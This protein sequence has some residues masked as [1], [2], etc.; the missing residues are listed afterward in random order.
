[1]LSTIAQ[2]SG[3]VTNII[4][5]YVFIFPLGMGVAGAAWATVIGQFISLFVAM[6]FHYTCNKEI[7]GSFKYIKPDLELIKGIYNIGIS[8]AIM[9][10]LLSV[11]MAG[12]NAILGTSKA[13]PAI[14][15]GSFGIYYKIQQMALFSAF[16]LSNTIISILS[17]NYGMK[18]KKRINDCIKYG[19]A[20]TIIVTFI[21]TLT[22]EIFAKPLSGLF[23]LTGGTTKEIINVCAMSL[24]IAS[25]GYVFMG[26]SIAVQGVLQ[27]LGY[28]VRPLIISLFRLVIFVFPIAYLFTLSDDVTDMVWWTFPIAEIFTAVISG[29]ILKITYKEKISVINDDTAGFGNSNLI[30]SISRQHGTGGKEIARKVAGELEMNFFDKEEIKKFAIKNSM[31]EAAYSDDDLYKFYLSLDAEKDSIIKQAKT[32]KMI[33]AHNDCV[34]V[35][36][37]ADYILKDSPNIVKIFLYA[38]IKYRIDKVREMYNDTYNEAEKHIERSD[39]S[40][41][42]YYEVIANEKWG[43]KENYDVCIDC[44][45][46]SDK[47]ANIICG[48]IREIR[49]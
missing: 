30:I 1:M 5:D 38:P 17:F 29:F 43:D 33:A 35:G 13:D 39:K 20:D 22:F 37:C 40:R 25:I 27:S 6:Y 26:F 14:L 4:L 12:M 48:Y 9:Q 3:A 24:R 46:G 34:I 44:S 36:R 8:A 32:I 7:N 45:V 2:I 47:I 10:A 11:M 42:A 28:A 23:A 15:V 21:L 18:D 49:K 16:G 41:A 19:I 31:V